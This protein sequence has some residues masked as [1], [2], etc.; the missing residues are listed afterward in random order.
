MFLG[1]F[2]LALASRRAAPRLSLGTAFLACQLADLVWPLF[3]LARLERFAIAPG[4]TAVTPLDFQ[5]YP[6]SHSLVALG[7]WAVVAAGSYAALHRRDRAAIAMV[8]VLVLSHWALD[9]VAHRPDLP[10]SIGGATR[11]GLELWASRGAT[12]AVELTL[13]GAGLVSY[14]RA[15]RPVDRT[16]QWAFWGLAVFLAIMYFAAVFGPPPPDIM[17]VVWSAQAVWLIVAWGYWVDR[18]RTS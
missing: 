10:L 3:V 7:G 17:T 14:A 2:A 13:F 12:M 9:F 11:V 15:T 5:S 18:H 8:A 6:F 4:I 1:H 16:G